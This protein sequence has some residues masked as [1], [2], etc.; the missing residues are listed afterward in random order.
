MDDVT[1]QQVHDRF[2][3]LPEG[4]RATI[5]D[6]ATYDTIER[7]GLA[8]E[9]TRVEVGL[10]AQATS[11]LMMGVI[12][13][14]KYV[15]VLIDQLTISQCNAAGQ[16]RAIRAGRAIRERTRCADIHKMQRPVRF[17]AAPAIH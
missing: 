3:T 13:P 4:V 10:L 5:T 11:L 7:I 2:M 6:P 14:N 9:L 15:A 17:G 16:I 8:H 1:Q 12:Q